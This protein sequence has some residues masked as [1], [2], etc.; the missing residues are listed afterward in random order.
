MVVSIVGS[1]Q[2]IRKLFA[3]SLTQQ[4]VE[5][6]VEAGAEAQVS[7]VAGAVQG[8][9]LGLLWSGE[10]ILVLVVGGRLMEVF[11]LE[12]GQH[13]LILIHGTAAIEAA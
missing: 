7:A 5:A 8:S 1:R 4:R 3:V 12:A 2:P 6:V 13:R 10:E 9:I 11:L